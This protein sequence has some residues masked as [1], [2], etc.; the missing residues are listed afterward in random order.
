MRI[1]EYFPLADETK[2]QGFWEKFYG[3][4]NLCEIVCLCSLKRSCFIFSR[5][6]ILYS[7]LY[8]GPGKHPLLAAKYRSLIPS[9]VDML[10]LF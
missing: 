3:K 7:F 5:I 10:F 2:F 1:Y 9:F 4:T 6:V 8:V